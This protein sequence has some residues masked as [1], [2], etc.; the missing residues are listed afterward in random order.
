ML[1]I[2]MLPAEYGDALLVSWGPSEKA[3]KHLLID[4]GLSKTVGVLRKRLAKLGTPARLELLVVT[5]VDNDPINGLLALLRDSPGVVAPKA[6]WF[7][8]WKQVQRYHDRAGVGQGNELGDLLDASWKKQWNPKAIVLPAKPT[9]LA[10]GMKLTLLSPDVAKLKTL[11]R[12]WV[13]RTPEVL[14][15]DRAGARRKPKRLDRYSVLE[16][17]AVKLDEDDAPANGSSIAFLIEAEGK[18]VLFGADAH[19]S[20][21]LNALDG[22]Q[23]EKRVALDAFK[24]PHH[25]SE[26]N[27]SVELL[28]KVRCSRFLVSSNGVQFEHPDDVALARVVTH[29]PGATLYFNYKSSRT[30][31]WGKAALQKKQG[32]GAEFPKGKSGLT[33]T[34]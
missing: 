22:Y 2:E 17:A 13:A 7:N 34:L 28:K 9:R 10:G 1:K 24:L 27:I 4:G 33:V 3:L 5:H 31:A 8:G 23:R 12:E 26:R 18:R 11:A 21:L 20:V 25:G 16:L 6:I 29:A 19:P 30:K 15:E 32:F 14:A